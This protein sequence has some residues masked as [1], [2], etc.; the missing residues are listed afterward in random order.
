[1]CAS[2]YIGPPKREGRKEGNAYEVE[3]FGARHSSHCGARNIY[4]RWR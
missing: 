1:M 3:G 4:K 2:L